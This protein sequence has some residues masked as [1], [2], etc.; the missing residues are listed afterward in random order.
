MPYP[1]ASHAN[2]GKIAGHDASGHSPLMMPSD[3][4]K[5]IAEVRM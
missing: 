4:P 2:A 3:N 5:S 1:G